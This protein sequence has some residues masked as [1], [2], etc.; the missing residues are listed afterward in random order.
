LICKQEGQQPTVSHSIP[1]RAYCVVPARHH[2][3]EHLTYTLM[4][5]PGSSSDKIPLV[6]AK[7]K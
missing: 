1:E 7:K 5:G 2:N 4:I 3:P 6:G